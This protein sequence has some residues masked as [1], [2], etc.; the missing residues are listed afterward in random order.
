MQT[1]VDVHDVGVFRESVSCIQTFKEVTEMPSFC[2]LS[3]V[4]DR[5][6]VPPYERSSTFAKVQNHKG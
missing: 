3:N 5:S 2:G 4:R 1:F 6:N